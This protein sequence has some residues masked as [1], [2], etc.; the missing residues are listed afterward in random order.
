MD[1][2]MAVWHIVVMILIFCYVVRINSKLNKL[3]R[4]D[5]RSQRS[6][7]ESETD[8]GRPE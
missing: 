3:L 6:V 8:A 1:L 2:A 4:R 7:G 5:M